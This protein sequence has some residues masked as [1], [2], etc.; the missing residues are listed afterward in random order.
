MYIQILNWKLYACPHSYPWKKIQ[1]L[2]FIWHSY[3]LYMYLYPDSD[4]VKRNYIWYV[5]NSKSLT[6]D[7]NNNSNENNNINNNNEDKNIITKK[8]MMMMSFRR[9]RRWLQ[10]IFFCAFDVFIRSHL[11]YMSNKLKIIKKIY[12]GVP[13]LCLTYFILKR[14]KLCLEFESDPVNPYPNTLLLV[15]TGWTGWHAALHRILPV[16]VMLLSD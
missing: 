11:I 5:Y 9:R 6:K 15:L 3:A 12:I 4:K 13:F 7:N 1:I 2:V 10:R 16:N 8:T 14:Q